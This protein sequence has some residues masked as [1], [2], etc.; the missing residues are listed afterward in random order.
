MLGPV[1]QSLGLVTPGDWV[2]F[3]RHVS[4]PFTGLLAPQHDSR[5]LK[6][7]IIPK[8]MAA[9]DRFDVVFVRPG[10]PNTELPNKAAHHYVPPQEGAWGEGDEKLPEGVEPYYLRADTG[11]RWMLGGVLSRPMATTVQSGGKFAISSIESSSIY[12]AA[13][14]P[15]AGKTLTFKSTHHVLFVREGKLAVSLQGG[16]KSVLGEGETAVLPAGTGFQLGFESRFVRFWS[17]ASGDGI[18]AL[19]HKAGESYEAMVLPDEVEAFEG[20]RLQEVAKEF[21]V[22]IV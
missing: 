10:V 22:E 12:P 16:E 14:Q 15:F 1:S 19:V 21:G 4:E 5:D 6:S 13:S 7:L 8:V 11:P 3:F 20:K 2:D 18:E 17:F 9:K